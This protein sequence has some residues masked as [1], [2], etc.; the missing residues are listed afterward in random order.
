MST[1]HCSMREH[2]HVI[3]RALNLL[4][5]SKDLW[6]AMMRAACLHATGNAFPTHE[7][8]LD[9][10]TSGAI[11]TCASNL[12]NI[13]IRITEAFSGTKTE[14]LMLEAGLRVALEVTP[15]HV[16]IRCWIHHNP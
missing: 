8:L 15:A 9:V 4:H 6:E 11:S 14:W 13:L 12:V 10:P 5:D 1:M 3:C 16:A 7:D 2:K